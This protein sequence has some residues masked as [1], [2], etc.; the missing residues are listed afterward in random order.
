MRLKRLW[1][2]LGLAMLVVG[3]VASPAAKTETAQAAT[4]NRVN[5]NG[6][7]DSGHSYSSPVVFHDGQS[8]KIFIAVSKESG[9]N[10]YTEIWRSTN[11]NPNS[12]TRVVTNGL[13]GQLGSP[14]NT[15]DVYDLSVFNGALYLTNHPNRND[16]SC[17]QPNSCLMVWRSTNGVNWS[18]VSP[19][20]FQGISQSAPKKSAATVATDYRSGRMVEFQG[21]LYVATAY[22]TLFDPRAADPPLGC[23][24]GEIFRFD[25]STWETAWENT[26]PNSGVDGPY[27]VCV[28][29][30]LAVFGNHIYASLLQWSS[31]G[32]Y[33][34]LLRSDNGILWTNALANTEH[35]IDS[36]IVTNLATLSSPIYGDEMFAAAQFRD[37]RPA[38]VYR[39][40]DGANWS[41]VTSSSDISG[42]NNRRITA[43]EVVNNQLLVGTDNPSSG[44]Q[45]W[46]TGAGGPFWA[47][48]NQGNG[49]F[50]S[51]NNSQI[52]GLLIHDNFIYATTF[53]TSSSRGVQVWRT[54]LIDPPPPQC[55]IDLA[56]V[57]DI[58]G[59]MT[60][61][62]I[63][64][65]EQ[66]IVWAKRVLTGDPNNP[67][68]NL[69]QGVLDKVAAGQN[70]SRIALITFNRT[71]QVNTVS[72]FRRID[73]NSDFVDPNQ[74]TGGRL[75]LDRMKDIVNGRGGY[76]RIDAQG[77][78]PMA[79]AIDKMHQ[80]FL[81][82]RSQP[83]KSPVLILVGDGSPTIDIQDRVYSD[84]HTDQISLRDL[85]GTG[86]R[87]EPDVRVDNDNAGNT[88]LTRY[89][90]RAG[91]PLADLMVQANEA[92]PPNPLGIPGLLSFSIPMF[93]QAGGN[94]NISTLQYVGSKSGGT[95]PA[96]NTYDPRS[97]EA[98][99]DAF[100]RIIQFEACR[101]R[102]FVDLPPKLL[103]KPTGMYFGG[104]SYEFNGSNVTCLSPPSLCD[105][106]NV[107]VATSSTDSAST[108]DDFYRI[109][110]LD[111]RRARGP[112]W[113]PGQFGGPRNLYGFKLTFQT[114]I[115]VNDIATIEQYLN[116]GV[117]NQDHIFVGDEACSRGVGL[118]YICLRTSV[119]TDVPNISTELPLYLHQKISRERLVVE[120]NVAAPGTLDQFQ[121]DS[122]AIAVGGD[123]RINTGAAQLDNYITGTKIAWGDAND[124]ASV[125]AKLNS[126]F[127]R[128]RNAPAVGLSGYSQPIWNLNSAS[129]DPSNLSSN[130]FSSPPEGKLWNIVAPANQT[131]TLGTN[132]NNST[133][134]R[135]SGTVVIATADGGPVN[136]VI[137]TKVSC[138]SATRLAVITKGKITFKRP[139][140]GSAAQIDCGAYTSLGNEIEFEDASFGNVKGI[141]VARGSVILPNPSVLTQPYRIR[142]DSNFA[143]SPTVLLREL[144]A[145][146][147][148][149]AS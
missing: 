15:G 87:P 116:N 47:Q 142:Y 127:N 24:R 139:N 49:G 105:R 82:G 130:S 95:R 97:P 120:G 11:G 27:I 22:T 126:L 144:L 115:R 90:T 61:R 117:N 59:S 121:L 28:V 94:F 33:T 100:E 122:R 8:N 113:P 42:S 109:S 74:I 96:Y 80:A 140:P 63:N 10:H 101:S 9:G 55:N 21:K 53:N 92:F 114:P 81:S 19:H 23:G 86:F 29:S 36:A 98:L 64:S 67:D 148:F 124:P 18:S 26:G 145:I 76:P 93:A 39:S 132:P 1:A 111:F 52:S 84:D 30:G 129:N 146:V 79:H 99:F 137:N 141:F 62:F 41:Q 102:L 128:R 91:E 72:Q 20:N 104:N 65:S 135:G 13:T 71:S 14:N 31:Q 45:V 88:Y 48:L 51:P 133:E 3:L 77:G 56:I 32:R 73:P 70:R 2:W 17:G 5:S 35:F 69:R 50:G 75:N 68:P 108:N 60:E 66:K 143:R 123:V 4:W 12:W 25:G 40:T 16:T 112:D 54:D 149:A 134:F 107:S 34:Q 138:A 110:I 43:F 131:F 106:Y 118:G 136:V 78:T 58:S 37:G 147:F 7:G 85:R 6:F 38:A 89:G 44:G 119:L 83:F 46:H 57:L 103:I 125:S